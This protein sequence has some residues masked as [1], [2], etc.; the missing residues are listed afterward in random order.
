VKDM[1]QYYTMTMPTAINGLCR[2]ELPRERSW[3]EA[4]TP[5]CVTVGRA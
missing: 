5:S 2:N 4:R 3:E 1:C